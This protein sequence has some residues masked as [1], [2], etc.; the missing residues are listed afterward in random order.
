MGSILGR[1]LVDCRQLGLGLG[2]VWG[3]WVGFGWMRGQSAVDPR[4]IC[5]R[6]LADL[7]GS[8]IQFLSIGGRS[9]DDLRWSWGGPR[10]DLEPRRA[11][12][13]AEQSGAWRSGADRSIA[14]RSGASWRSRVDLASV[15]GWSRVDLSWTMGRSRVDLGSLCGRSGAEPGPIRGSASSAGLSPHDLAGDLGPGVQDRPVPRGGPLDEGLG[16]PPRRGLPGRLRG[17]AG[18]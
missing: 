13:G 2:S 17:V 11:P 1:F 16:P 4:P 8:E 6:C 9:R 18:L 3:R 5:G 10:V 12:R 15:C 7:G 14:G